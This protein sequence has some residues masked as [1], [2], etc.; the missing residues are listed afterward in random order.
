MP[1]LQVARPEEQEDDDCRSDRGEVT[2]HHHKPP[3][4]AINEGASKWRDNQRGSKGEESNER[5]RGRLAGNLP[6]P[7]REGETSHRGSE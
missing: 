2:Q 4:P 7:N 1:D 3:I 5:Q 6:R